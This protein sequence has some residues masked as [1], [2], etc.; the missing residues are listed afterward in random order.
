MDTA[1]NYR[2][3]G[4]FVSLI[5]RISS[6]DAQWEIPMRVAGVGVHAGVKGTILARGYPRITR[7]LLGELGYFEVGGP[8]HSAGAVGV[9]W[10]C[11]WFWFFPFE[12]FHSA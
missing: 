2:R 1:Q 10:D 3:F 5:L 12:K 9:G 4:S 8:T 7:M 11:F 6:C